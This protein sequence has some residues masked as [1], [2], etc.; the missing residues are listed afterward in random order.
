MLLYITILGFI[1]TFVLIINL[2]KTNK[3]NIYLFF[4]F[5]TNNI[6]SLSH[7]A[8]LYSKSKVLIA[9]M[10][11]HF[12]PFYLLLGP[13]FYFYVRGLLKDEYGLKK[14][15]LLHFIPAVVVF[16]NILPYLF[17]GVEYK[18]E[19]AQKIIQDPIHILD[20]NLLFLSPVFNFMFR[21]MI[22]SV[23]VIYSIILIYKNGLDKKYSGPQVKLIYRWLTSLIVMSL[24]LYIGFLIFTTIGFFVRNYYSTYNMGFFLIYCVGFGLVLLNMS[25][26]FFPNIL[27]GL[28]QLDYVLFKNETEEVLVTPPAVKQNRVFEISEDKLEVLNNKINVYVEARPYLRPDF[29]LSVMAAETNIPMHHLS[30]FFNEH[31]KINFNSWKNDLKITFV[32]EKLE[33]GSAEALT[34]DALAKQAGFGSRASF[35][36]AF[37]QKTGVTPSEYLKN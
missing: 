29:N 8:T 18:L 10:L 30:Y 11:V 12:T 26:L 31:M 13:L 35:I 7:Y 5:L 6:Y 37:K 27:Y 36:N 19:Y 20:V 25:L 2:R 16:V 14:S 28:P 17:E 3:S 9:I 34:L 24:L 1:I 33:E 23:Y 15:D 32:I 4:F 21:P 22:A